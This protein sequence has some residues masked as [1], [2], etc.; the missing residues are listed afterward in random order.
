V[1]SLCLGNES[2]ITKNL[3]GLLGLT[4]F[5]GLSGLVATAGPINSIWLP[6]VS[7]QAW[8]WEF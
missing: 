3:C 6:F 8:G 7:F 1:A 2:D 5:Y 4:V